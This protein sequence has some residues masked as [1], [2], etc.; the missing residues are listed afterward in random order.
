MTTSVFAANAVAASATAMAA[1][2][3]DRV[4]SGLSP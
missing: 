4:V 1:T 2:N 3:N